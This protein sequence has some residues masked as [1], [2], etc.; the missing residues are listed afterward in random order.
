M[1]KTKL[2]FTAMAIL[3]FISCESSQMELVVYRQPSEVFQPC[4]CSFNNPSFRNDL[5]L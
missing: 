2:L 3:A 4:E 1:V 5:E